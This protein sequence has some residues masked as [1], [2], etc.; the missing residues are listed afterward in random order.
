MNAIPLVMWIT[1]A[2]EH[3]SLLRQDHYKYVSTG[4]NIRAMA[5]GQFTFSCN[6]YSHWP[7]HH[8]VWMQGSC[9]NLCAVYGCECIVSV[10]RPPN[11]IGWLDWCNFRTHG[12]H[13]CESHV[14]VSDTKMPRRAIDRER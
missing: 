10:A 4:Q 11:D 5:N 3:V 13:S 6:I 12:W 2:S 8:L 7:C 14:S 9:R 1:Y